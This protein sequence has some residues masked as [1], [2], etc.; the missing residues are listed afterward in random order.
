MDLLTINGDLLGAS[1]TI[2]PPLGEEQEEFL[3]LQT[4]VRGH[5]IFRGDV[6]EVDDLA[7]DADVHLLRDGV[8]P[9]RRQETRYHRAC[10]FSEAW[11]SDR[12]KRHG[13]PRRRRSML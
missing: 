7:H 12:G 11:C 9:G 10:G 8:R 6:H 3:M 2:T 1:L 4:Q 5:G 13:S